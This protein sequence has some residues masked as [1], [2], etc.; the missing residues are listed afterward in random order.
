M[1]TPRHMRKGRQP[2]SGKD[3]EKQKAFRRAALVSKLFIHQNAKQ[4]AGDP[5]YLRYCAACDSGSLRRGK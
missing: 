5:A 4:L 1:F 2:A 3:K